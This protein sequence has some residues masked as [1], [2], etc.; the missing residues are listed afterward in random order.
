[1]VFYEE[2]DGMQEDVRIARSQKLEWRGLEES[3]F[4]EIIQIKPCISREH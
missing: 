2:T 1:M 3:L 4:P